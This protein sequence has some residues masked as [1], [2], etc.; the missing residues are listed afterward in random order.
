M[1]LCPE[2][3]LPVLWL[4]A[5]QEKGIL[6]LTDLP[7][8]TFINFSLRWPQAEASQHA[9]PVSAG[10]TKALGGRSPA[11]RAPSAPPGFLVVQG[12]PGADGGLS[13]PRTTQHTRWQ[14]L[15]SCCVGPMRI[16][17]GECQVLDECVWVNL[18]MQ[19]LSHNGTYDRGWGA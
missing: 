2:P 14:G 1:N 19:A 3:T 18:W 11:K 5:T 6:V 12:H 10:R 13:P 8:E 16:G 7:K 15:G 9:L 17:P 4:G